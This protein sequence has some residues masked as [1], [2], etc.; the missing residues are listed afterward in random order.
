M[1][2]KKELN[3]EL[4][5]VLKFKRNNFN[6]SNRM[7]E[8]KLGIFS[9]IIIKSSTSLKNDHWLENHKSC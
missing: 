7:I 5:P 9:A 3:N 6:E 1:S 8:W 4:V 2:Q